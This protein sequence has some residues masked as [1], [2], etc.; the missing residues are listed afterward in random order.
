MIG[1]LFRLV[2]QAA[3]K[4][5]WWKVFLGTVA[6]TV[7]TTAAVKTVDKIMEDKRKTP[8]SK[9]AELE[10]LKQAGEISD[11]QFKELKKKVLESYATS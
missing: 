4:V 7:A 10:A 6:T 5:P 11:E 9:I 3:T 8:R 1:P 2:A